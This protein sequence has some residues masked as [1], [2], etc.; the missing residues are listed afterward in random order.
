MLLTLLIIEYFS[1]FRF[2]IL[3]EGD[4]EM[5]FKLFHHWNSS[6]GR[7]KVDTHNMIG[8]VFGVGMMLKDVA[9]GELL[10]HL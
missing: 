8:A 6:P 7:S 1:F 10:D 9:S 3:W 4:S 5:F 2:D